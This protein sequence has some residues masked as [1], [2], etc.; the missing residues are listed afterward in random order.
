M[1]NIIII[2]NWTP[3][4]WILAIHLTGRR[5]HAYGS[6][7]FAQWQRSPDDSGRSVLI[8]QSSAGSHKNSAHG[9]DCHLKD[10]CWWLDA[11]LWEVGAWLASPD[12]KNFN[13]LQ[14]T[15]LERDSNFDLNLILFDISSIGF[16]ILIWTLVKTHKHITEYKLQFD[17]CDLVHPRY[18]H[19]HKYKIRLTYVRCT[20]DG[21]T[22]LKYR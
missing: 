14:L 21:Q 4:S 6:R 18:I 19:G 22:Y 11:C 2:V 12:K 7:T 8:H 3:P 1:I 15:V 13:W 9:P 17:V 20:S 10:A 5:L 16:E